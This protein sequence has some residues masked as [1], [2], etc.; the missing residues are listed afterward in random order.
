MA[1]YM[2]LAADVYRR[3]HSLLTSEDIRER[4]ERVNMAQEEFARYLGVGSASVK[5]WEVGQVQDRAMD[6][7][8]RVYTDIAEALHN[9][10]KVSQLVA[11][12]QYWVSLHARVYTEKPLHE[13]Q[14]IGPGGVQKLRVFTVG[15]GEGQCS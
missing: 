13:W 7:L 12:H 14:K 4:R 9:C 1:E 10:K 15:G 6:N 8:I 2:R 3:K 11:P 5:R